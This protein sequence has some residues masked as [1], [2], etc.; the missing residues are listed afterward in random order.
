VTA[1]SSLVE[2]FESQQSLQAVSKNCHRWLTIAEYD[3]VQP[4]LKELKRSGYKIIVSSLSADAT[5]IHKIDL[6]EKCAFVFGNEKHGVTKE[7]EHSADGFFTIPMFG[8][9][10]SMNVSVAVGT[11]ASL[12][13][14]R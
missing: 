6:S 8:F 4:C 10:E 3:S 1:S 13:T 2:R 14:T 11:T 7:M 5:P 9:V 12:A